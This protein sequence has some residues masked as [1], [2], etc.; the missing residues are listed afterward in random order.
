MVEEPTHAPHSTRLTRY[1]GLY[2][3]FKGVGW[4]VVGLVLWF[5]ALQS[6]QFE[7]DS[8]FRLFA[9]YLLLFAVPGVLLWVLGVLVR[10]RRPMAWW[11]GTGYLSLTLFGKTTVGLVNVPAEIW[12]S[13]SHR[14]PPAY[15]GTATALGLGATV[16]Y[17]L[18]IG[19]FVVFLSPICRECFGINPHEAPVEMGPESRGVHEQG[20]E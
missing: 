5:F 6:G 20:R 13:L 9:Y 8:P 4:A 2:F 11:L 1:L 14:L 18:D 3:Y 12:H 15:F 7:T 10:F 19:V 17:A 16:V